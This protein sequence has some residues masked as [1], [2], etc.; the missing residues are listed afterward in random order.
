MRSFD[1]HVARRVAVR[2]LFP[3]AVSAWAL[4]FSVHN[5]PLH[6]QSLYGSLVGNVT[7][8]SQAPIPGTQ[9]TIRNQET[10]Q[11][12]D[13]VTDE[14]GRY[15][16]SDVGTGTYDVSFR[17]K[18]F[19]TITETGL[20]VTITNVS[21][22]DLSM[23]IGAVAESVQVSAQTAVL[24]TDSS[25]VRAEIT[26]KTLQDA[27]IPPGRNYQ[28]LFRF[29]PGVSPPSSAH[30]IPSNPSFDRR[31]GNSKVNWNATSKLNAFLRF[32]VLDWNDYDQQVF[33]D[34]AGGPPKLNGCNPCYDTGRTYSLTAAA[35][36]IVSPR[37]VVDEYYGWTGPNSSFSVV[38]RPAT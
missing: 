31:I 18:G 12:R 21:R 2:A 3:L 27:P 20:T 22:L 28:Q 35:T 32:G 10:G 8:A 36:Y 5:L 26:S 9:V 16:F 17:K 25:E 23:R 15:S 6:A 1:C 11:A 33:G 30:S 19:A 38:G 13:T 34:S 24:Q 37:I 4:L 29:I 7:D 14:G